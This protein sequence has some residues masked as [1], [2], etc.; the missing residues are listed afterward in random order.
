LLDSSRTLTLHQTRC[1]FGR[2]FSFLPVFNLPVFSRA[3]K[4]CA[5]LRV[6]HSRHHS[7]AHLRSQH[8]VHNPAQQSDPCSC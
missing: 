5:R 1:F 6:R 4:R 7:P 8:S 2:A 3:M